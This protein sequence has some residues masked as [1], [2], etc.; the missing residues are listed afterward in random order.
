MS[1]ALLDEAAR[2]AAQFE[3]PA[4]D[5]HRGVKEYIHQ[6]D[7]GLAHEGTTLSQIPTYVTSVPNGTEK[8]SEILLPLPHQS[9]RQTAECGQN[10]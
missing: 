10:A 2:I 5:V 3:Y 1:S 4:D 9:R 8:V 6:M 7:E